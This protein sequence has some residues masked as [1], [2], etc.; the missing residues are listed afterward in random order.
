MAPTEWSLYVFSDLVFSPVHG[1]SPA[2]GGIDQG[3]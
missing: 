1:A 3:F 2:K